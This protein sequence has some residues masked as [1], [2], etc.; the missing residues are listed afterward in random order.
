MINHFI[1]IGVIDFGRIFQLRRF[2]IWDLPKISLKHVGHRVLVV[3]IE[4][5]AMIKVIIKL[6]K[7]PRCR[8]T[9]TTRRWFAKGSLLT[10]FSAWRATGSLQVA[11]AWVLSLTDDGKMVL[12]PKQKFNLFNL[13][14]WFLFSPAKKAKHLQKWLVGGWT[15]PLEKYA[16]QNGFIFPKVLELPPP[17][18]AQLLFPQHHQA[19]KP[20]AQPVAWAPKP[21]ISGGISLE[22]SS[23]DLRLHGVTKG[24][25]VNHRLPV[26]NPPRNHYMTFM[27]DPWDEREKLTY[28]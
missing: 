18:W 10:F 5:F 15:N 7:V 11:S 22:K 4:Q 27:T 26:F 14:L 6:C 12:S 24:L 21:A 13:L 1:T 9:N 19:S 28:Y 25:P 2:A 16:R 3:G 17:R 23:S 20:K 8:I